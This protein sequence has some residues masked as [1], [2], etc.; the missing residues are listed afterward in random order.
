VYRK[1]IQADPNFEDAWFQLGSLQV[2]VHKNRDAYASLQRAVELLP[3]R[4]DVKVKLAD[5]ELT[6]YLSDEHHSAALYQKVSD[7]SAQ[8]LALDVRS[9]DGLRLKAHLA[10]IDRNYAAE[11]AVPDDMSHSNFRLG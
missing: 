5:L 4:A 1:A 3:S 9:F 6:S 2:R 7:L 8:L 10:A 11:V